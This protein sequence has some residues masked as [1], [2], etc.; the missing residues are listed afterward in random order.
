MAMT[1]SPTLRP[2]ASRPVRTAPPRQQ[3]LDL[4]AAV[5]RKLLNRLNLEA[6]AVTDR[7]RAESEIRAVLGQLLSE[8]NDAAQ[9][10]RA[11]N[12]LWRGAR[13]RVRA[14]P[15]GAAAAR[16]RHQR[17]PG[18]HPPQRVRGARWRARARDGHV[19]GR[20]APAP[21]HRSHCQRRR[22]PHRRQLADGGRPAGRRV[23][24]QRDHP[25]ARG[26]R[27]DPVDPAVSGRAAQGGRPRDVDRR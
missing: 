22:P 25:A 3:Y 18:Q 8:E 6:L 16:R 1:A 26:G 21:R 12:P 19:P 7:A 2:D 17:H 15:A 10:F 4:R 5:H 14:R 20:S 24:R 11:R 13:R 27:A 23:A 9:P